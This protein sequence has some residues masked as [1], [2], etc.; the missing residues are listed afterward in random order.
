MRNDRL[1]KDNKQLV[2]LKIKLLGITVTASLLIFGLITGG[3]AIFV[4]DSKAYANL[5]SINT[6]DTNT[7]VFKAA[8]PTPPSLV[9]FSRTGR[10]LIVNWT[11]S[12]TP[13]ATYNV[14]IY[15]TVDSVIYRADNL[16]T[17]TNSY[18]FSN[19]IA[20]QFTKARV[21][22][23]LNGETS[24]KDSAEAVE[25]PLRTVNA[26]N[27]FKDIANLSADS[28]RAINWQFVYGITNGYNL[29][30]YKPTNKV[31]REQM[32]AFLHHLAGTPRNYNQDN[33]FNDIFANVFSEDIL[34]LYYSDIASGYSHNR[35]KPKSLVTR[36]QMAIFLYKLAGS[37]E[38]S[39]IT[40]SFSDTKGLSELAQKSIEWLYN[41]LISVGYDNSTKFKPKNKLTREQMAL[42]MKR[43][44]DILVLN[45]Y[46]ETEVYGA[47]NFLSTNVARSTITK[48]SFVDYIP[49]CTDAVDISAD[50]SKAILACIFNKSE[51][52]VGQAG[53]VI[54]N[55]K[56][57]SY[58]FAD[59]KNTGLINFDISAFD[60]FNTDNMTGTFS[61]FSL[62]ADLILPL[63][64]GSKTANMSSCF[65]NAA[66][67]SIKFSEGFGQKV[68]MAPGMFS[69]LNI[70]QTLILPD[71]FG[72]LLITAN[73]M[74]FRFNKAKAVSINIIFNSQFGTNLKLAP[75]MFSEV[76]V[77]GNLVFPKNFGW[78][79]ESG[80]N[81]F[82][83]I[84]ILQGSLILPDNYC[85]DV[86]SIA[87][88]VFAGAKIE[89]DIIVGQNAFS[90]VNLPAINIFD[91]A[92]ILGNVVFGSKAY[93]K[94][95]S[96]TALFQNVTIGGN[97]IISDN[98]APDALD[99]SNFFSKSKIFGKITLP[100]NFGSKVINLAGFFENA[101]I[102][103]KI[104][105]PP[106]FAQTTNNITDFFQGAILQADIDWSGTDFTGK[107]N[108][109]TS[110]TFKDLVVNSSHLIVKNQTSKD[111]FDAITSNP[112]PTG[113]I[114][115]KQ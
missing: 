21:W 83:G 8:A 96:V 30:Q 44:S 88:L 106:Y 48:L 72:Q 47:T 78:K 97:L 99:M 95:S 53:G 90:Y 107:T 32:A 113:F 82:S 19:V 62:S 94:A 104:V 31:T 67:N 108:I 91:G 76:V 63:A 6:L 5:Q 37:P 75:G 79:I 100:D 42:L 18:I 115:V 24:Y 43:V 98:F 39:N 46:L 69:L 16:S 66:V 4:P 40:N 65:A 105:L 51:I 25:I 56:D 20:G 54:A 85:S 74:F 86:N 1:D 59:L 101:T 73:S 41:Q 14:E 35:F 87:L 102:Y 64:F 55:P 112:A 28:Q 12:T 49:A 92:N 81:V 68:T 109:N 57:S 70:N 38:I 26:T 22:S 36:E 10:V 29:D 34:W 103:N 61:N 7:S 17:S 15:N 84:I 50:K 71:K 11:A 3:F 60:A 13:N 45:S 2:N 110:A 89:G 9:N 58:L 27:Y 111:F 93:A 80:S 52:V 33:P 77:T 23:V 114:T